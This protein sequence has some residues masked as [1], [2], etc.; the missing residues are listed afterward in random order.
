LP[1]KLTAGLHHAVRHTD[2]ETSFVHH[3]FLNILVAAAV[4]V[5]GAEVAEVA[6]VLGGTD[7]APLVTA[8]QARRHRSRPLWVGFG[9]CSVMDPLTD[10]IRLGLIDGGF[11]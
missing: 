1:F 4:A 11:E 10:L 8:A 5:D 7:P 3:G 2:P 9:S 6:E